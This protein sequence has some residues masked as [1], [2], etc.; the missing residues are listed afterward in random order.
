[1]ETYNNALLR[2]GCVLEAKSALRS[3]PE[4]ITIDGLRTCPHDNDTH[5]E[6][7]INEACCNTDLKVRQEILMVFLKKTFSEH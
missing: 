3:F 1:M 4:I 6:N 5:S 2:S 7:W